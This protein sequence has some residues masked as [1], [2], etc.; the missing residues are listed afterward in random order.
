MDQL[1]QLRKALV[2]AND[3]GLTTGL[4]VWVP[5]TPVVSSTSASEAQM[6]TVV[7]NLEVVDN[8][9]LITFLEVGQPIT[10]AA[11]FSAP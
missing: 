5:V 2:L 3:Q 8:T 4:S 7:V 10:E 1:G 6:S 9:I 11:S